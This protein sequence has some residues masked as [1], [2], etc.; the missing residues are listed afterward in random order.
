MRPFTLCGD[1]THETAH[2]H[3]WG[4]QADVDLRLRYRG[5]GGRRI[6]SVQNARYLARLSGKSV[7]A[8]L[9]GGKTDSNAYEE[10]E[11]LA[12]SL[13]E[14]LRAFGY[15]PQ[16]AL[17]DLV[18]NSITA[19]S[20]NVWIDLHWDGAGSYVT[21]LDDGE[22]MSESILREAMR[23]GSTSPLEARKKGDLGRFGL[24]LKTASFSQCRLLTV[25]SKTEKR[26]AA[27][28]CWDLDYVGASRQ[29]RLLKQAQPETEPRLSGLNKM[30]T[31]TV[32]SWEKMDRLV[33]G[34]DR[35]DNKAHRRFLTM[36]DEVEAHLGMVF[37]R[38][39][40]RSRGRLRLW[41]NDRP[42]EP[43]DPYLTE[44]GSE[45]LGTERIALRGQVMSVSPYVLPHK[46]RISNELHRKASGPNGWNAQQG[47]YVYRGDRLL[48]AGSWLGLPFAK[49]EHYKL[50]RIA[51][52]IPTTMDLDWDINV[53]KS[54]AVPPGLLKEHLLRI[55][56]FTRE[57][58]VAVFRHR[59]KLDGR[60]SSE[61]WVYFW[62]RVES[63]GRIS[64]R[65][66][67]KHPLV[68]AVL[69]DLDP[70][71][72]AGVEKILRLAEET[73]PIPS[74]VVDSALRPEAHE[75]PFGHA[76][77]AEVLDVMRTIYEA[78]V[79]DGV[80]PRVAI[81]RLGKMEPF[82]QFP[83]LVAVVDG[84]AEQTP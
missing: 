69:G 29:W 70:S 68:L 58:A 39:L 36:I 38:F 59:G 15:S 5:T 77:S 4:P 76:K 74:I 81:D 34:T 48:V 30:S 22:G 43:W 13:V 11:P 62:S 79:A 12:S 84:G 63:A 40:S 44:H 41:I 57:R 26:A 78:M 27:T 66:N 60:S 7:R 64:Y 32:I 50:A 28:R 83:E 42:V 47:F 18:D 53:T 25:R 21:I 23:P 24:G 49:E 52:D 55:A 45:A 46:S 6:R 16:A 73:V 2:S 10:V 56:N 67:R 33:G 31:G 17:A 1:R 82:N 8:A 14:S 72:S 54:K 61:P 19:G 80:K 37:H 3:Q 35:D 20:K 9:R 75:Q 65:I 71:Q 51:L